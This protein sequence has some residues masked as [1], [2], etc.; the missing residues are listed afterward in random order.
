MEKEGHKNKDEYDEEYDELNED[1]DE[2]LKEKIKRK[3]LRDKYKM[4]E[5][6]KIRPKYRLRP[7]WVLGMINTV[8]QDFRVMLI[9]DRSMLTLKTYLTHFVKEYNEIITDGYRGYSFLD[10]DILKLKI[11]IILDSLKTRPTTKKDI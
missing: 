6:G 8:T 11:D 4:G 10:A 2:N 5:D 7:F 9:P 1:I 3:E